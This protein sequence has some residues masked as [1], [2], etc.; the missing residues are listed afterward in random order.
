MPSDVEIDVGPTIIEK[1]PEGYV[2]ATEEYDH[3]VRVLHLPNG[4][5]DIMNYVAGEP[6]PDPKEPDKGL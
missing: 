4:H 6:F 2:K 3:S 1:L 5:N